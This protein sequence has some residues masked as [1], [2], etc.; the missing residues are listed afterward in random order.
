MYTDMAIKNKNHG[1]SYFGVL[2]H[3]IPGEAYPFCATKDE[4]Y[5][6]YMGRIQH[7]KGVAIAIDA[8]KA[9]GIR[10]QVIGTGR[11]ENVYGSHPD[12]VDYVGVLDMRQKAEIIKRARCVFVPTLYMEPFSF[13]AL[14]SQMCGTPVLCSR[15]GG[16]SEIIVHGVT[17]YHC[18]T[19]DTF[20]DG[21]KRCTDLNPKTI[22]QYA[23]DRFSVEAVTKYFTEY[24][25]KIQAFVSGKTNYYTVGDVQYP[26][27]GMGKLFN[28]TSLPVPPSQTV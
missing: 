15:W 28:S 10:L 27:Q 3:F 23:K 5:A 18:D 2:P 11:V 12:H 8:C 4:N 25:D 20:V 19:L 6:V 21:L 26:G 1:H 17:G 16:P 14:E 24:F 9:F 13:A 22:A 7:D